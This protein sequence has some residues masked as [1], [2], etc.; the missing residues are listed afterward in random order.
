MGSFRHWIVGSA[1]FTLGSL[2]ILAKAQTPS[3]DVRHFQPPTSPDGS[4]YVET[5]NSPGASQW[6]V[7]SW[8]S[9]SF[10]PVVLR[11]GNDDVVANLISQQLSLDLLGSIGVTRHAAIGLAVPAV[12]AQTGD[13]NEYTNTVLH[14]STLSSQALGDIALTGKVTLMAIEPMGGWGF[15]ALARVTAP[16]GSRTAYVGEGALTSELRFLAE[17]DLL[18]AS[19][20]ATTG[21][22]LRTQERTFA[23]VTYGNEIPWGIGVKVLPQ[24]IGLDDSGRWTWSLEAHGA[25]PAGPANPFSSVALSP[26]LLGASARYRIG[27]DLTLAG[28]VEAPLDGAVGVPL[29]RVL[30][31]ISYAPRNHDMDGD[32]IPDDIDQCPELAEDFDGFEDDDGC[33][34]YDNDADGVPDAMDQCPNE[35]E[36]LDDF[37]DDDGCPDPDNDRDGILD[38]NDACP[39]VWG[40]PSQDPSKHGCPVLDRDSDGI[41]DDLDQCPDEPEDKDGFQDEDGCPDLDNDGDGIPDA[42]DQCPLIPGPAS[43]ATKWH[44]CPVPDQD[45]DTFDDE[46]D[47]CPQEPETWNGVEDDDGCPDQGGLWLAREQTTREGPSLVIRTPIRFV[48]PTHAPSIHADSVPTVRAIATI[49][50][51]HPDWVLAVGTKPNP[52]DGPLDSTHSLSRA[53][54]IVLA[55]QSYTFRDGVAETVSWEAVRTQPGAIAQGVG[56]LV[57][58]GAAETTASD[59]E[60]AA[61]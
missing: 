19:V 37:E 61:P 20:L 17:Y 41:P 56:F 38:E 12:L 51:R 57:L 5:T 34:D 60:E 45:G 47:K 46:H 2:P 11:D 15:A 43:P 39:D 23:G 6:N 24:A 33:P 9:W 44:G 42:Q 4:L 27:T 32:G 40:L 52:I 49:L 3:L 59:Q 53:F 18:A 21:F 1:L 25:L 29:T 14:G 36:D 8:L 31:G 26:A 28:G 35:P 58:Y 48:G 10:R 7:G 22:K 50:N 13:S 30:V 16:T 55:L 54:A